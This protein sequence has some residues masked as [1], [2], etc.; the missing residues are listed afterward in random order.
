MKLIAKKLKWR[1]SHKKII[2][3]IFIF[4]LTDDFGLFYTLIHRWNI[5]HILLSRVTEGIGPMMSGNQ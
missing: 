3:K 1:I 5:N 2:Q 4:R